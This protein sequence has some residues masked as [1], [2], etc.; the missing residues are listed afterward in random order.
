MKKGL[1]IAAVIAVAL[2]AAQDYLSKKARK[3]VDAASDMQLDQAAA[4]RWTKKMDV[5]LN[6]AD[7]AFRAGRY[8]S[9]ATQLHLAR[10][11]FNPA[12]LKY[13]DQPFRDGRSLANWLAKRLGDRGDAYADLLLARNPSA[14]A[15]FDL[16]GLED[17]ASACQSAKFRTALPEHAKRVTAALKD[18]AVV[19]V[20]LSGVPV[21]LRDDLLTL[22][23]ARV[24]NAQKTAVVADTGLLGKTVP[25]ERGSAECRMFITDA[26]YAA[27]FTKD[28]RAPVSLVQQVVLAIT[29]DEA[30][31]ARGGWKDRMEFQ[32][33]E[34]LAP[35]YT[36]TEGDPKV[37][38]NG[39]PITTK[40]SEKMEEYSGTPE[41]FAQSWNQYFWKAFLPK[42]EKV[43]PLG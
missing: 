2:L 22:L 6:E 27:H 35:E 3:A 8:S 4:E 9:C 24:G 17:V 13:R 16:V 14:E 5:A 40:K 10:S 19:S 42:L 11:Y 36:F 31:R 43:P 34:V 38:A 21:G 26:K 12:W 30:L 20:R 29:P 25:Y 15:L 37:A 23:R 41:E 39:R 7:T 18:R 33:S 1:I 32:H 28:M